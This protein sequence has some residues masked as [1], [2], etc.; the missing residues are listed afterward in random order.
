[1]YCKEFNSFSVL[2]LYEGELLGKV[3]KLYFDKITIQEVIKEVN[4]LGGK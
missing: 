3:D 1:M 2:S 4:K